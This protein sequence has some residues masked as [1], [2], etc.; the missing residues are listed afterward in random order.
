MR[1]RSR[2]IVVRRR[3]HLYGIDPLQGRTPEQVEADERCATLAALLLALFGLV[4]GVLGLLGV[5]L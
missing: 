5:R 2:A 4:L 1:E 3:D